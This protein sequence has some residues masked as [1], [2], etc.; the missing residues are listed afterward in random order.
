MWRA[1]ADSMVALYAFTR[2]FITMPLRSLIAAADKTP[3]RVPVPAYLIEHEKGLAVFDTGLGVPAWQ[4]LNGMKGVA[5]EF[6]PLADIGAR[7]KAA[8]FDPAA[9][10]FIVNSHLH[11]DHSGGNA[12]LANAAVVVQAPELEAARAGG[13]AYEGGVFDAGHPVLSLNGEHDLFG[14]GSVTLFPTPGHT[15]GHQC[16]RVLLESGPVVLAG[17]CC[18]MRRTMDELALPRITADPERHLESIKLLRGM[19]ERGDRIFF[20]HDPEQWE[21]MPQGVRMT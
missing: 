13:E 7:L 20:G 21:T 6:D 16:A 1:E 14:D 8:G 11:S 2:G 17:D 4:A 19:R 3:F 12:A 9:V 15:P 18:Y 5:A 10:R